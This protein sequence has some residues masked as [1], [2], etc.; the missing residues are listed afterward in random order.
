MCWRFGETRSL[1]EL[2]FLRPVH[3]MKLLHSMNIKEFTLVIELSV[4]TTP[5][6][7]RSQHVRYVVRTLTGMLLRMNARTAHHTMIEKLLIRL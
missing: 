6:R 2:Q 5:Q 1:L 4:H 3:T 7:E